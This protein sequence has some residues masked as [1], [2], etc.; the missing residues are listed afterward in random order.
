MVFL[1]V[2]V[3][4][5]VALFL[6]PLKKWDPVLA[7]PPQRLAINLQ[8]LPAAAEPDPVVKTTRSPVVT[9]PTPEKRISAPMVLEEIPVPFEPIKP[10]GSAAE[11]EVISAQELRSLARQS[12]L[13]APEAESSR[14]LGAAKQYKAPAN[15][16]RSAGAPYLAEFDNRF[17]GMAAP[18]KVEIVD[19]WLAEDGSH[20]VVINTPNG[21]TFCGRAEAY[22]PMQPLVEPI[23]MF[24]PCAG[25][26]KRSFSMPD[27]YN[28]GP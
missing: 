23:M 14:Q 3:L 18:E 16:S 10:P 26:G 6:I 7:T 17:N 5:H 15:W 11:V 27:R 9:E 22:N 19:R 25:G 28:K 1:A 4:L 2:A 13:L 12:K 24:R 20:N 21:E 8:T